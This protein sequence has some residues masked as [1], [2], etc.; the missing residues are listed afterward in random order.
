MTRLPR[1]ILL[2]SGVHFLPEERQRQVVLQQTIP[3]AREGRESF[4]HHQVHPTLGEIKPL[5][6]IVLI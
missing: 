3:G 5:P 4:Q 2:Q 6:Q 1:I